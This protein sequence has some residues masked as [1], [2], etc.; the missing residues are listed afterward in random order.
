[1]FFLG[2]SELW[3]KE[4]EPTVKEF[5]TS[6]PPPLIVDIEAKFRHYKKLQ[7]EIEEF[8][9]TYQVGSIIYMTDSLK[10]ALLQEIS[11]W[12]L[13][14]GKELN[15]KAASDMK[16]LLDL[17][18][19]IQKRLGRP[20]KDLDD[21]R[22]HMSALNQIKEKEIEIDRTITPIEETYAMLNKYDITFNDGNA[23]K[24]DSLTYGWKT[25]NEKAKEVQNNLVDVQPNFKGDLLTKVTQFKKDVDVFGVD[26]AKKG[27]MVEGIPPR[28]ASDRLTIFQ[29][30]FDELWRKYETYSGG[31]DLFGLPIT[32][33]DELQ[34]IK[35]ELNLLQ[36]LY[37][38][39]NQVIDTI[40]GYYDIAWI[41][42]NI[43][44]INA[45]LNEFQ[46]KCRKLPKGL[47]EY[48]AFNDLKKTIDDFNETCPLLEMMANKSM[49]ERHWARIATTTNHK[50]DI[51]SDNFLLRDIMSAPLLKYKEEIEDICISAIKEKDIEAK[52]KQ[53]IADWGNQNFQFAQFKSRGELLLKGDTTGEVIALMEDSLMVLGSLMSNRYNAPFK[54]S[55]QEWVSKLTTTTEIIENWMI[56]QN[57]W[58]YLEAVFVGGDI[59]KQLPQEAKRFSNIDKSWQKIMQKA[60]DTTNVV[61]CCVGDETLAQL[62]PHLLEQLEVCQKSLTGYLEKKRLVFPRFFFVSD[63][64]L[65]EILGQA[66]D[67]HTIQVCILD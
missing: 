50:F 65:L 14:Y 40:N 32:N 59:A 43:E 23:E 64:A 45:D 48:Q 16:N 5:M 53:V 30:K 18:E 58:I 26:Y 67:S 54:K 25:L 28:E 51:D 24:V 12:K 27:P 13:A 8:P 19:D 9:L 3:E 6:K 7:I 11:N 2:F 57:L 36:K 60:H 44:K 62:L 17:V 61:S 35:K 37:G 46:N 55:I 34:K 56:V 63:P 66:S 52:L 10:R 47:K 33:Y 1:M 21:I 29:A 31:E 42:V 4:P 49:K 22:L 38:L 41:D 20:C 39:Y 15:N